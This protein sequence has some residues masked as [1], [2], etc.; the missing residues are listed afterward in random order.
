MVTP[1]CY[2]VLE[3][4]AALDDAEFWMVVGQAQVERTRRVRSPGRLGYSASDIE[5]QS[6]ASSSRFAQGDSRAGTALLDA[7]RSYPT[8]MVFDVESP[9]LKTV[10]P[11]P[12]L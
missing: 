1:D 3:Q 2:R 12:P 6:F 7:P 5:R 10:E 9:S 11:K 8:N 4:L